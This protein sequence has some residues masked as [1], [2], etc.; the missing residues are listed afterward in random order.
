MCVTGCKLLA[1]RPPPPKGAWSWG[2]AQCLALDGLGFLSPLGDD[3][4]G[5]QEDYK[6]KD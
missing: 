4:I 5:L 3:A 1:S 6:Q 2:E